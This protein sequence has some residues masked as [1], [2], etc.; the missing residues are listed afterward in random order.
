M[1]AIMIK[2]L[3]HQLKLLI[4]CLSLSLLAGQAL[5]EELS[6]DQIIDK[7]IYFEVAGQNSSTAVQ[8]RIYI[9]TPSTLKYLRGAPPLADV[10]LLFSG[11]EVKSSTF[12][13]NYNID[14]N[15]KLE[16]ECSIPLYSGAFT[17]NNYRGKLD[18]LGLKQYG[19]E[20]Y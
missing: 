13:K 11:S 12:I 3:N 2:S 17:L 8:E 15:T 20:K 16:L 18:L 5:G 14:E 1:E 4:L 19:S 9:K 7:N 6:L 10:V